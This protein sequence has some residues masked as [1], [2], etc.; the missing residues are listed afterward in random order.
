MQKNIIQLLSIT[1]LSL[2]SINGW[3]EN[4]IY[5]CKNL[6]GDLLYQKSPCKENVQTISSWKAVSAKAQPPAQV[7]VKKIKEFIIKQNSNGSY[8]MA[9]AVNGKALTFVV[10]TGAS[11]IS[12]PSSVAREARISCKGKVDMQT[13]NGSTSACS[14]IIKKLNFGPFFIKDAMAVIA[15]NLSQPL[16]GMNVLQQLKIAQ[17]KGEMRLS[18]HE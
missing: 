5:K 15:P 9:G 13:A 1:V 17:E 6:K 7:P 10:D 16:L 11:F 3:G 12:I 14:T 18:T 8:F 2:L 4:I